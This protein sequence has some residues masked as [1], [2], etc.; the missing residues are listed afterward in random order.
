MKRREL[1][2]LVFVVI[3]SVFTVHANSI[4]KIPISGTELFN[5]FGLFG[6]PPIGE[7]LAPGTV[8]CPGNEPTGDPLQPCPVGSRTHTRGT[9][10]RSRFNAANP[11]FSG[12][13]FIEAN[14]NF[15]RDFTGPQWGTYTLQYDAGGEMTGSYQGVRVKEGDHWISPLH[16]T[17]HINGGTLSGSKGLFTDRIVGFTPIPIAYTGTIDGTLISVPNN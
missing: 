15:D 3:L 10:W 8:E 5:P 2:A 11:I 6:Q 14:A 16:A 13:F 12:W 7:F 1:T 4:E 17:G 9:K